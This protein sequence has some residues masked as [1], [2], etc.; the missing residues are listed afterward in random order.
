[1]L[2]FPDPKNAT[3]FADISCNRYGDK[4]GLL[5]SNVRQWCALVGLSAGSFDTTAGEAVLGNGALDAAA[6]VRMLLSSSTLS[7][8]KFEIH[9]QF[10]DL[11]LYFIYKGLY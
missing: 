4:V 7:A 2:F 11:N 9:K 8:A 10:M 5:H 3:H 1:M 6:G